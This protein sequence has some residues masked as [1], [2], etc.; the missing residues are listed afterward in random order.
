MLCKIYVCNKHRF[1]ERI[2]FSNI[3]RSGIACQ[4]YTADPLCETGS[5]I[6]LRSGVSVMLGGFH[7][8]SN[9]DSIFTPFLIMHGTSDKISDIKGSE[10][11][12]KNAM[13][14]DKSLVRMEGVFHEVY[15]DPD[16]GMFMWVIYIYVERERE[17]D[18][19]TRTIY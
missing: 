13:S 11:M 17:R 18:S 10:A 3:S 7:V 5:S 4:K 1:P 12:V 16:R 2:E 15:E 6:R 9:F 14:S 8:Q 19:V